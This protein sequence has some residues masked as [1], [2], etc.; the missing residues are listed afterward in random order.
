MK[1]LLA[2]LVVSTLLLM[3]MTLNVMAIDDDDPLVIRKPYSALNR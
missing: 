2:V 3:S 1:K